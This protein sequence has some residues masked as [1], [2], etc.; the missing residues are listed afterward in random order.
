MSS[1]M[2]LFSFVLL[3]GFLAHSATISN[4]STVINGPIY[5]VSDNSIETASYPNLEFVNGPIYIVGNSH[6]TAVN[7]PKLLYVNGPIYVTYNALLE[8]V[9]YPK[10]TFVNGPIYYF[11]NKE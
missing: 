11:G 8:P 6:L 5:I 10:I 1:K 4:E 2:F 7:F 9:S 3:L